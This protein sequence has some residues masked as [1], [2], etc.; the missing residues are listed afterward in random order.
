VCVFVCVCVCARTHAHAKGG[1]QT[2]RDIEKVPHI[3][4][5][6]LGIDLFSHVGSR[7]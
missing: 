1:G 4:E 2:D 7:D 6:L 5:Q 3:R